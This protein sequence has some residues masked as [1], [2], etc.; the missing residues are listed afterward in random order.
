MA[1]WWWWWWGGIKEPSPRFDRYTLSFENPGREI[2]AMRRR[3]R[4][5]LR[6]MLLAASPQFPHMTAI[7]STCTCEH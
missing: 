5:L 1:L 2:R 7:V 3:R 4:R 6:P